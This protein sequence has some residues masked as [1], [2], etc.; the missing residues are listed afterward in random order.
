MRDTGD[1]AVTVARRDINTRIVQSG[2][3]LKV[4]GHSV[5]IVS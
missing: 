4:R 1:G 3:M 2:A 5:E